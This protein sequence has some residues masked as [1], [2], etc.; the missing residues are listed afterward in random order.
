M[1]KDDKVKCCTFLWRVVYSHTIAYFVAG[2]CAVVLLDYKTH[3]AS[4]T[5]SLLM[6]PVN[7]PIV[8]LGPALQPLRGLLMAFVLWPFRSIIFDKGGWWKLAL[9]VFGLSQIC[10]I[11]P[12]PGS[13]DGIIYTVLPLMYHLLGL[14]EAIL[15]I[16]LFT[17][18]MYCSYVF[19]RRWISIIAAV[20]M[21]LILF[22]GICGYLAASKMSI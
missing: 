19:E 4:D 17:G 18:I 5:L 22:M 6:L 10:T 9:L 3:Y 14:P 11:G 2:L 21:C 12:T 1:L 7:S 16:L 8:A 20:M 13:F 15:Y